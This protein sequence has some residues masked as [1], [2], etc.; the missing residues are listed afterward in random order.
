MKNLFILII[1]I[2]LLAACAPS[3][4]AIQTAIAQTQAAQPVSTA[5]QKPTSTPAPCISNELHQQIS[6]VLSRFADAV[7]L[8][9]STP[10]MQLADVIADMQAIRR[11]AESLSFS[12]CL[13]PIRPHLIAYMD[14]AINAFTAFLA[15]NPYQDQ[16]TQAFIER[17]EFET[18]YSRLRVDDGLRTGYLQPAPPDAIS[19]TYAPNREDTHIELTNTDSQTVWYIYGRIYHQRADGTQ[20]DIFKVFYPSLAS[21]A[22]EAIDIQRTREMVEKMIKMENVFLEITEAYIETE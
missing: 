18:A 4:A 2:Y 3:E 6:D 15:E 5:T 7:T 9:D 19:I 1:I 8:G 21:S 13:T 11:D 17:E 22:S 14:S 12:D 16:F 10:R 20:E